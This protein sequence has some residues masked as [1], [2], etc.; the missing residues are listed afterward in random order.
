MRGILE[1]IARGLTLTVDE[2]YEAAKGMLTNIDEAV[3]AAILMGL[4]VRGE[5]PSEIAGFAKALRDHCVK[6][7]VQDRDMYIDTAGTGGD[8]FST[9]N[10]ST[11]AALAS[12]YLGAYVIKHGNRGVSSPSGSA[13]FLEALGFRIDIPPGKALQMV[14]TY[15]FTFAFAPSYHPA[16]RNVM[17]VRRKLGIRTIFNIVGPLA[18]PA[19]L[20]RQLIGIA[21]HGLISKVAEAASMIGYRHVILIHGEPGIDEVSVFGRTRVVEVKDG[22]VEEYYI[23]P[24]DLGLSLHKIDEVRVSS[25]AESAERFRRAALG[26]DK[27]AREFIAAN[28]AFALYLAGVVKDLKDGVEYFK[29]NVGEGLLNYVKELAEVSRI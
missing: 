23:E 17:P 7:P 14:S 8:G 12:A 21:E 4:R 9:L 10:A 11:A 6:I 15:R 2:A 29:S 22:R 26:L 18:N 13:D 1:K 19:L 28:T 25:P 27:A 3:A 16:M 24:R 5:A 20:T